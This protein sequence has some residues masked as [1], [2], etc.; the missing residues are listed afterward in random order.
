MIEFNR[1]FQSS[2]YRI[3]LNGSPIGVIFRQGH[4]VTTKRCGSC[5]HMLEEEWRTKAFAVSI[6]GRLW[7]PDG[8]LRPKGKGGYSCR[9]FKRLKDA[10]AK[11]REMFE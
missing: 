5:D 6:D 4:N 7:G 8:E 9:S 2:P 1:R 3:F 10:K 11:V